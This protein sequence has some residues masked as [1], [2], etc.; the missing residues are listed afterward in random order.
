VT[1][2]LKL[3]E[4]LVEE[5]DTG[6]VTLQERIDEIIVRT[7]DVMRLVNDGRTVF[8]GGE[9]VDLML[10]ARSALVEARGTLEPVP[11]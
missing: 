7:E 5:A 6:G 9:V 10:D 2:K 3:E 1:V 4:M 11:A 8:S